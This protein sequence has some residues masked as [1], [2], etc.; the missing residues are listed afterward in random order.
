MWKEVKT[1]ELVSQ[2]TLSRALSFVVLFHK[3]KKLGAFRKI[4]IS[5]EIINSMR[6]RVHSTSTS[7]HYRECY[8]LSASKG[9]PRGEDR[10]SLWFQS[11]IA[12]FVD[13][14][15]TSGYS[16]RS[17]RSATFPFL[18]SCLLGPFFGVCDCP[19]TYLPIEGIS[20]KAAVPNPYLSFP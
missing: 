20:D 11:G 19:T 7:W 12:E 18:L 10:A 5:G 1:K 9:L 14:I 17:G 8:S 3:D 6:F 13:L 4:L 16:D 2:I 15:L